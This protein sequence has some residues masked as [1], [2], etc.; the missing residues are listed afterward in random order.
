MAGR[1]RVLTCLQ[2]AL[3]V[4]TGTGT[5]RKSPFESAHYRANWDMHTGIWAMYEHRYPLGVHRSEAAPLTFS[6]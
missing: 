3:D 6:Q 2:N 5:R 1:A 4:G